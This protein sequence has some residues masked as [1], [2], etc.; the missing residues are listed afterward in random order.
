MS[1]PII[2]CD[3]SVH[4]YDL[5]GEWMQLVKVQPQIENNPRYIK[6]WARAAVIKR[7]NHPITCFAFNP[8]AVLIFA[9]DKK[10]KTGY[11][12]T[13]QYSEYKGERGEKPD[14]WKYIERTVTEYLKLRENETIQNKAV[15]RLWAL[16]PFEADD[17]MAECVRIL[18]QHNLKTKTYISTID[19]DL[20]QL[21]DD[22]VTFAWS[23]PWEP[24]IKGIPETI[25]YVEKKFGVKISHP[26]DFI[27]VKATMGDDSDNLPPGY[28]PDTY[29]RNYRLMALEPCL[30]TFGINGLRNWRYRPMLVNTIKSA[31]DGASNVDETRYRQAYKWLY[32]NDPLNGRYT[33]RF[34][35]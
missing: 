19:T 33:S 13:E 12:R 2:L 25:E 26:R 14:V 23:G 18:K 22:N 5:Y 27:H 32:E 15:A 7:F 29:Q 4:I 10:N 16:E 17:V 30:T 1:N 8:D 28:T 31:D 20:L 35:S 21:V 11:W 24:R 3:V 9:G 6:A 34:D